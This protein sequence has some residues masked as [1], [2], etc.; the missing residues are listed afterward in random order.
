[1]AFFADLSPYTYSDLSTGDRQTDGKSWRHYATKSTV[2]VGWLGEGKP[3]PDGE[4]SEE[5]KEKLLT[6][7]FHENAF[8]PTRGL[9]LCE[10]PSCRA[11]PNGGLFGSPAPIKRGEH[12]AYLG[13]SEIRALGP[14]NVYAAPTMIYHYVVEHS[15]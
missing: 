11:K 1:M 13:S 14:I 3:F 7:C 6:F 10:L 8:N 12:T 9:H 2:N 15:Y 4:P 5:F